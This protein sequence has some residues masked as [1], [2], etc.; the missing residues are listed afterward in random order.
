MDIRR[1]VARGNVS[2]YPENYVKDL[3]LWMSWYPARAKS[4]YAVR[5]RIGPI[6]SRLVEEGRAACRLK[7]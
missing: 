7:S 4:V 1:V 5:D 3:E 2:N 6:A